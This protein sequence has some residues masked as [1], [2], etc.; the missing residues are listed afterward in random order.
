M[1]NTTNMYF[2]SKTYKYSTSREE[3]ELLDFSLAYIISFYF[4]GIDKKTAEVK[5]YVA[6]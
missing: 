3:G 2:I 6:I 4:L 1:S 5:H